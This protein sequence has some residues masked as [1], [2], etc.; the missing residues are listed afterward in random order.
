MNNA[1]I[2]NFSTPKEELDR[3]PWLR[4][5]QD[6]LITIL[7]NIDELLKSKPWKMLSSLVFEGVTESLERRL[8][9]EAKKDTPNNLE[10]AR[11]NGQLVWA[12]KYSDLNEL[13]RVFRIELEGIKNQ[14]KA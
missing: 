1:L 12:K 10:L 14:L 9:N 2:E 11:I 6:E 13:A 3:E 5:R 7:N 4:A 8:S